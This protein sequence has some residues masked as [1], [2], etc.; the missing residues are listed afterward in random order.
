MPKLP[1]PSF[2][3]S[4]YWLAGLLLGIGYGSDGRSFFSGPEASGDERTSV[5]F[6]WERLLEIMERFN[7]VG[8]GMMQ[9]GGEGGG[10]EEIKENH[11]RWGIVYLLVYSGKLP[12]MCVARSCCV[13][14][15]NDN[16]NSSS[17]Q[18]LLPAVQSLSTYHDCS[19]V[20]KLW[21]L[22]WSYGLERLR[23]VAEQSYWRRRGHEAGGLY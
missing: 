7:R 12:F 5:D 15:V 13:I 4:V 10:E 6:C 21:M 1:V 17:P 14:N 2:S 11:G 8:E 16:I 9:S 20:G 22:S 3:R 19:T 18:A 23:C